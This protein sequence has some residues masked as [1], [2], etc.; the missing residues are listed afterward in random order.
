MRASLAKEGQR[1]QF[2]LAPLSCY[3]VNDLADH[4]AG[5]H[6]P[7]GKLRGVNPV[8]ATVLDDQSRLRP[9]L[10]TDSR[11]TRYK[12][13]HRQWNLSQLVDQLN[14]VVVHPQRIEATLHNPPASVEP[15]EVVVSHYCEA[16][17]A[18]VNKAGK[19]EAWNDPVAGV[20]VNEL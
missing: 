10:E 16:T 15:G 6:D 3:S 13:L 18:G 20:V 4:R 11:T 14:A 1:K 9:N 5:R 7:T 8:G 19:V 12:V 17:N 2:P